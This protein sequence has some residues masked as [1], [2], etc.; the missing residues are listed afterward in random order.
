VRGAGTVRAWAWPAAR[1]A[2]KGM[3]RSARRVTIWGLRAWYAGRRF[4]GRPRGR[5]RGPGERPRV[6]I[7]LLNA[8]GMGGTVRATLTMAGGLAAEHEVEIIS[9]YRNRE[10]P[11]FPFPRGVRVTVL[12]DLKAAAPGRVRRLLSRLPSVLTPV[13]ESSFRRV[14][15]WTDLRLLSRLATLDCD[16][17]IATRPSLNL[18]IAEAAPY[19]I[20][21][22]GQD[23]M[24]LGT[25]RPEL[26]ADITR[27]YRRLDTLTV[28][29]EVSLGDYRAALAGAPVEIVRIPNALPLPFSGTRRARPAANVVLAA[30][31]LTRQKGFDLLIQAYE[32]L[33]AE[34]PDWTLR[35]FGSGARRDE[36]RGMIA[37][38]GLGDRIE[39]RGRTTDLAGK[40]AGAAVYAL[41]SRHEGLP[42][43]VIEA[44]GMGLPVVA[45]D[46]P[47]G[48]AEM[49]THGRDGLLVPAG[50]V[51]GFAAALRELIEDGDLRRRM[52]ERALVTA[53][54]Y[55]PAAIGAR[56]SA[57]V[58]GKVDGK[59][60]G[61]GSGKV[62]GNGRGGAGA[63]VPRVNEPGSEYAEL[64]F[65]HYH[66]AVGADSAGEHV[67]PHVVS[68][69]GGSKHVRD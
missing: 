21:T 62:G 15:L 6:R 14:S 32:P 30:G 61:K 60:S 29:T 26:R 48:P 2:A 64:I 63:G 57:L 42:M 9:L 54:A 28:L 37:E 8:Y 66:L 4:A 33:A 55:D 49:I 43:V 44:M 56:W 35:I 36:L 19:G 17:L 22:I 16:V 47:T 46:C 69:L 65:D 38:Q 10:R 52:G 11:F 31:R 12:D 68:A 39:L 50:D 18:L 13:K 5:P 34:H 23:H 59:V 40:M 20:R 67:N 41:P 7:L 24:N 51:A 1:F 45:F 25:Y 58:G 27:A 3:L 53:R